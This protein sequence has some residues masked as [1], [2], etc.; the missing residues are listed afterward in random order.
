MCLYAFAFRQQHFVFIESGLELIEWIVK[1]C[2]F[3]FGKTEIWIVTICL[4]DI[5]VMCQAI[6]KVF[7][8]KLASM[9]EE[10]MCAKIRYFSFEIG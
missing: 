4:Q 6:E 10:V 8:Q 3:N 7:V 5:V 1:H 9:P 2:S